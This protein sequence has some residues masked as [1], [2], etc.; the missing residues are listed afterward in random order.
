MVLVIIEPG[1][2]A[3]GLFRF[4]GMLQNFVRAHYSFRSIEPCLGGANNNTGHLNGSTAGLSS[5]SSAV[6]GGGGPALR[7]FKIDENRSFTS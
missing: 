4:E 7:R 1:S 2:G 3:N 5:T 6:A